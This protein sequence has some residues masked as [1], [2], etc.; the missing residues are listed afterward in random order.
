MSILLFGIDIQLFSA[1]EAKM[2]IFLSSST[3]II[4]VL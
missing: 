2:N 1:S 3:S 4:E